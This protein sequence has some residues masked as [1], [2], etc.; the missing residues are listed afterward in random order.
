[1]LDGILRLKCRDRGESNKHAVQR[2]DHFI[3]VQ[4]AILVGVTVYQ[5]FSKWLSQLGELASHAV[6]IYDFLYAFNFF[7]GY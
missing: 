1:M 4:H 7:T 2:A 5:C 6:L 3:C